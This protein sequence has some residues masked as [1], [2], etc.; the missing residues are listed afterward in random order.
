ML[1]Q[2]SIL[3]MINSSSLQDVPAIA[4]LDEAQDFEGP[5]PF[6]QYLVNLQ[7]QM[8][9]A[10]KESRQLP[11]AEIQHL[12]LPQ[13]TNEPILNSGGKE[14]PLG[15][16]R[17]PSPAFSPVVKPVD[18]P[19]IQV[20]GAGPLALINN[21]PATMQSRE[22]ILDLHSSPPRMEQALG[23]RVVWMV[24]QNV[25]VAE[26]QIHPPHLGPL[27]V[28]ISVEGEQTNVHFTTQHVEVQEIMEHAFPR[29]R[30][31]LTEAGL[32]PANV[33]I[34]QQDLPQGQ[35]H[36]TGKFS[37]SLSDGPDSP[38]KEQSDNALNMLPPWTSEGIGL[39]DYFA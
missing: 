11:R 17:F 25:Q 32:N 5:S 27:Q 31:V 26:L 23:N 12:L 7:S 8:P 1:A 33:N 10:V 28:R 3:G 15:G 6:L 9:H 30:H 29:L 18:F 19:N 22:F 35:H 36:S 16:N 38:I 37:S 14:L 20:F 39:I 24:G 2:L 34:S 13:V 21:E 4:D